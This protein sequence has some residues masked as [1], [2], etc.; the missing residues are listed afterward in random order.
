MRFNYLI[1]QTFHGISLRW[2]ANLTPVVCLATSFL[3]LTTFLVVTINLR[4][5][6]QKLKGEVRI[7]VYLNDK[8]TPEQIRSLRAKVQSSPEVENVIY[9][10]KGEAAALMEDYLGKEYMNGLDSN[11]FPASFQVSLKEAHKKFQPMSMLAS[12][13]RLQ[14]GVEEVEFGGEWLSKLDEVQRV[15]FVVDLVFGMLITLSGALM[16][17]SFMR[18]AVLSQTESIQVMSLLGANS[19]DIHLPLLLQGMILGGL[20][21]SLGLLLIWAGYALFSVKLLSITFLPSYMIL[22]LILWGMILGGGGSYWSV[23][24]QI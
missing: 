10:S 18:V 23:K 6:S 3:V 12:K 24:K 15:F 7:E 22:G 17:S 19:K 21:A 8:I 5:I 16:V 11:A 20:G 1:K 14:E 13:I 9:R 2:R 4:G